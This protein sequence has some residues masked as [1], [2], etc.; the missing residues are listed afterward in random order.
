MIIPSSICLPRWRQWHKATRLMLFTLPVRTLCTSRRQRCFYSTKSMSFARNRWP[1]TW[2]KPKPLSPARV[3]TRWCCLKHL[4]PP[5]CLTSCCYRNLFPKLE[6]SEKRLS[7]T[8]STPRVTSAISTVKIPI[9][10][11]RRSPMA[12]LWISV[13]LPGLGGC[14]VGRTTERSG[15]RQPAG[16]RRGCPRRG[17]TQLRRF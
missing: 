11:I 2:R 3:K 12:R 16:K 17:R 15:Q 10:L 13:L 6:E 4:R 7:I 1:Q 5:A 14:A 8:A 9:R